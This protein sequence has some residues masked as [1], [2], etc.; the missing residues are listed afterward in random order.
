MPLIRKSVFYANVGADRRGFER[1]G[2]N[3][4]LECSLRFHLGCRFGNG[5]TET[6]RLPTEAA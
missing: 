6:K 2:R 5:M 3:E 1:D 4:S